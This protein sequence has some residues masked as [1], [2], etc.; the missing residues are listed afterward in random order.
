MQ[1]I[2]RDD[3]ERLTLPGRTI[4]KAVGK[5]GLVR[6]GKM[7]VGFATYSPATG[8]M[9]EPHQHAEETVYIASAKNG[10]VRFGPAKDQMGEPV[11]VETGQILH[12]PEMEWHI[13]EFADDG[14]VDA[15]F[16][17]GQVDNIRPEEMQK[18]G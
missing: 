2:K 4:Q 10:W 15:M 11:A 12:F 3:M 5:D 16:I 6:S 9:P 1:L 14:H 18:K 17:Y 7:T 8:P 13:F